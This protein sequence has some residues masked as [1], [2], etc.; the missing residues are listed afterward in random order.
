MGKRA[1]KHASYE[2]EEVEK[3]YAMRYEKPLSK[4]AEHAFHTTFIDRSGDIGIKEG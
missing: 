2:N 4:E 3:L 1:P